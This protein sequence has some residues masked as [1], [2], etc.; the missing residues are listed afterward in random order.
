MQ[1]PPSAV[2]RCLGCIFALILTA[3]VYAQP[4]TP[5]RQ[6]GAQ[7][8]SL[9]LAADGTIQ[10]T[11]LGSFD[12]SGYWLAYGPKGEPRFVP[13]AP[14]SPVGCGD[15][16]DTTFTTNGVN[17]GVYA[18][19]ADGSGNFYFGGSFTDV[20]GVPMAGIAKWNGT[21]WSSLGAG[22]SGTVRSIA[23]LG[24]DIYVGGDFSQA[25][26][27]PARNVAKWNGTSWSALSTGLGGGTHLVNA[28]AVFGNEIYAGG[29]FST[30]DGSPTSGIARWD[31]TSWVGVGTGA[32]FASSLVVKD[33]MMYAGSF[34]GVMK[35]DGVS[36]T[37]VG[38]MT[39][40][41]NA[42]AFSGTDLWA[43]GF[44]SVPGTGSSH[45]AMWNGTTW[46]S[47]GFFTN[48]NVETI[49]VAGT[50]VYVGGQLPVGSFNN[51]ARWNG[52]T[53]VAVGSGV[54]G[55]SNYVHVLTPS[56][57]TLYLGGDFRTAG[58]VSAR[59]IATLTNGTTWAGFQGTGL[60]SAA[61][62]IAVSGTDVYVGGN[63]TSAGTI[64]ANKIAK[65]NSVT[66]VW[67]A[68]GSGV[69][70]A[71]TS[72]A[73]IAVAGNK[74]YTGGTFSS[75]G[76]VSANN[77]AVWN[78]TGWAAL[79]TGV[80]SSVSVI[81]VRGDDV[82]V[83]GGFQTAGGVT[84][85]R[86]AK[87][88]GTSWSGLNSTILPTGVISMAFMGND[89]YVG[90][91][92]TTVANPA[93][94]SK[95]DGTTWTALGADLGDRGV[96]SVAVLG[97]DVYV[98]GG[99][100]SINGVTVNRIAK[101]N[102]STWSALGNGLPSPIGNLNSVRLA[103]SGTDLIATGDFTVASGGPA[104]RI[105]RWNGTA[106][107]G[108]STGLNANGSIVTPAGGD[109]FVGGGFTTAGCNQSPY[110]AR[111]R[112]NVWTGTTNTD[113]HTTTN[114]GGGSVP[115]ANAGV[116]IVSN[117]AS[118]ATADVTV[119]SLIVTGGRTL[120]IGVGRTL[121]VT[122]ALDLS[123]GSLAGP[124]AL[125]VN[126]DLSLNNGN[127]SG[128]GL[129][130]IN[131]NLYLAGGN[132]TGP[133]PVSLTACRS[134]SLV[135]GS[136]TSFVSSPLTRC[137]TSSGTYRF[138]VGTDSVYSPV[139]LANVVGNANFTVEAKSGAYSGPATGLPSNRLQRWWQLTNGGITQADVTFNYVDSEVV[140]LEG[141]YRAYRINGGVAE[142]V[143]AVFNT[144]GNTATVTGVTSF[145]PWTLADAPA[146]IVSVGGRVRRPDGR[147]IPFITVT[148][149]DSFGGTWTTVT[150][151]SGLYR[152]DNLVSPRQYTLTVAPRK[153]AI[154]AVPQRVLTV[155]DN[156]AN[157]DFVTSTP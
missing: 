29:L 150:K 113:W 122:G 104:E 77:I 127:V 143:P 52:S 43:V 144:T 67:S 146:A 1:N 81:I 75:I 112:E 17:N 136:S 120:T 74:V 102:G 89:L 55:G 87:W 22:V 101:W 118:I 30:S 11:A 99:F 142:L 126:G 34:A 130:A 96:S 68:L 13:A 41:V 63:F 106:W 139:A 9:I 38:S 84:A 15:G 103:V 65:W 95:Y 12:P 66:N 25:G 78:G 125:V 27:A 147:G 117:D 148:M 116:S 140:G 123:N 36:W 129:I 48:G 31:G 121:T 86:V 92:T 88:N 28:V 44:L 45:V 62:A 109:I 105:A 108:L 3:S 107:S 39:G 56:G 90:L 80:N 59:N 128:L 16:W 6:T 138:P 60:D 20:Q 57:N 141:A 72:I 152:F 71:N 154:F 24:K 10:S 100:T 114:W 93:Y 85:N 111:W 131:G 76:G 8:I 79:G 40:T 110:F 153:S 51:I 98:A 91:P 151:H 37:T 32:P 46:T 124:G 33:G 133:G 18:I 115:P 2:Y 14:S 69:P 4:Q 157:A 58:G 49:A 137:V 21:T 83:G 61:N 155:S 97:M 54:T 5:P 19:V 64:S 156:I 94:F 132:V 82:Y 23:S 53:F 50:D 35:W 73:A 149:S 70:A 145:S 135:G 119:S 7:P 47:K 26:G 134:G 42:I